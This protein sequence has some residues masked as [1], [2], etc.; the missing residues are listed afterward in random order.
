MVSGEI[1][2]VHSKYEE[3]CKMSWL[4]VGVIV[5]AIWWVGFK[6]AEYQNTVLNTIILLKY[7]EM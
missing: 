7:G 6:V 1:H 4:K 3:D 5:S 2:H